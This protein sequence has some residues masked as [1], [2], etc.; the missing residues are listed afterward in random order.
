MSDFCESYIKKI[1][2][3]ARTLEDFIREIFI[4]WKRIRRWQGKEGASYENDL[5]HS[6]KTAIQTMLFLEIEGRKTGIDP[7][8]MLVL[9]VLHDVGEGCTGVDIRYDVKNDS[10]MRGA[11]AMLE[12]K[13]FDSRFG[14][15]PRGVKDELVRIYHLQD[16]KNASGGKFFA[17][18]EQMGYAFFAREEVAMPNLLPSTVLD[19]AQ[20]IERVRRDLPPLIEDFSRLKDF[21]ALLFVPGA[22]KIAEL[23]FEPLVR[24]IIASWKSVKAWPEFA[25]EEDLLERVMKGVFLGC[26]MLAVERRER[27]NFDA[28]KVLSAL[29]VRNFS[30]ATYPVWPWR[31]KHDKDFPDGASDELERE[32]FMAMAKEF[33]ESMRAFLSD[34]FELKKD[35]QSFEGKIYKAIKLFGYGLFALYEFERGA[36]EYG[37][38]LYNVTKVLDPLSEEIV[39]LKMFYA[40]LRP[41]FD[42][43]ALYWKDLH[44]IA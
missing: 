10:R 27:P 16:D 5:E 32:H 6:F 22:K 39:S 44:K 23:E 26:A 42:C 19:F 13:N 29:L 36:R 14:E 15:L 20:V 9:A 3:P 37:E 18:V 34:C 11:L 38:V 1:D 12:E 31:M 43:G 4:A 40:P 25:A 33:P 21:V 35:A 28:Y 2:F 8:E 30:K 41:R 24:R 7:F 17:A